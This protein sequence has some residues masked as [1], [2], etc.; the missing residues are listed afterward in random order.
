MDVENGKK[1]YEELKLENRRLREKVDEYAREVK[2]QLSIERVRT[3]TM[4]MHDSSELAEVASVFFEQ[5]SLRTSTPDRF[6]IGIIDEDSRSIDF[7]IT[8]N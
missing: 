8:D 7:W 2:I 3:R 4:A 1:L 5:I 6:Y